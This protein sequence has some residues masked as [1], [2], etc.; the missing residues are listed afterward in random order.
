M[1]SN[2]FQSFIFAGESIGIGGV[3]GVFHI[4]CTPGIVTSDIDR[5]FVDGLVFG[6]TEVVG[7][8]VLYPLRRETERSMEIER[9]RTTRPEAIH[10]WH[11]VWRHLAGLSQQ[12]HRC[13]GSI[14]LIEWV[15]TVINQNTVGKASIFSRATSSRKT[16]CW[17]NLIVKNFAQNI[18]PESPK[19]GPPVMTRCQKIAF[20]F[21]SAGISYKIF[22][23]R[24]N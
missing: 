24:L 18:S 22:H 14:G 5:V 12:Y 8:M 1:N 9:E 3:L 6:S 23:S 11:K 21:W 13:L 20:V 7:W 17:N 15:Q 4:F 19:L 10:E 2:N 16:I